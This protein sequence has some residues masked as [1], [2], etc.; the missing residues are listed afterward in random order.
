MKRKVKTFCSALLLAVS[1]TALGAGFAV[2]Q[3]LDELNQ[4]ILNNP[5]DASLNL[6]YA[7]L[8]EQEGKPR[9]ALA[10]YER[11]LINDPTNEDARRGYERIRR[12]IE[13]DYTIARVEVG[14]RWDSN[15]ANIEDGDEA[16]SEYFRGVVVHEHTYGD[17][18]WRSAINLDAEQTPDIDELDYGY[19]GAQVGPMIYVGPHTAAIPTIGAGVSTLGGDLLFT[20]VNVGVTFEGRGDGV[21]YW[22]RVRGGWRDYGDDIVADNGA[23]A[24]IVA[25]LAKPRFLSDKGT[26]VVTPWVRWSDIEGSTYDFFLDG[27]FSP[28]GYLEY[29][30]DANYNYQVNDNLMLT[31]GALIRQRDFHDLDRTDF[32]TAP[33]VAAT[34]QNMLPCACDIKLRYQYRDNDSDAFFSDYEGEQVSL[35]LLARF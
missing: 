18:R 12:L 34:V 19:V 13:P 6:R 3:D 28:G 33:A 24:E 22:T 7:Q 32:Y 14:V 11:I 9:L 27:E 29:G 16:V 15:P 8:A 4:Q 25:G 17:R 5:A 1:L 23:Y 26:A 20:D 21:S 2:A 35:S 31:A 10:A 30:I